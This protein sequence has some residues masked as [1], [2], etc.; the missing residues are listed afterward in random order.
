MDGRKIPRHGY[1]MRAGA[2]TG[3]VA[4]GNFSP[5]LGKGIGLGYLAPPA[6]AETPIEIEIRG[7]WEPASRVRLPFIR[8]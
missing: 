7:R 5:V 4:S 3:T 2:S 8:R 6:D 1:A